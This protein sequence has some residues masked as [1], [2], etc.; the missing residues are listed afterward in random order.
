MSNAAEQWMRRAIELSKNGFPAPNPHVGCV[1]VKNGEIVG[2]AYHDHAGAPHAEVVALT[3]AREKA[4]G[5]DV[6]VTLEPCNHQGRTGPCSQALIQ[7]GVA[8]VT[9]ACLDPNPKAKGGLKALKESGVKVS[10]GLMQKEA[11]AANEVFLKSMEQRS[12]YLVGKVAMSLD[13]RV[14]MPNGDSKWIT[15][16]ASRAIGHRLRAECGAVLVGRNTV[17]RDNPHLTARVEGVVNQ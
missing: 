14:A 12:P 17:A 3:Q 9:A 11:S 8:N 6:F 4:N 16:E 7:A 13:G 1:I 2:E 5:A 15:N 10:H